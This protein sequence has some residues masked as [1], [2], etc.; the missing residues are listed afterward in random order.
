MVS[1]END[2]ALWFID[3]SQHDNPHT[4]VARAHTVP[5]TGALQHGLRELAHWVEHGIKPSE[6]TYCVVDGQVEVPET[7]ELRMGVQPV[8]HLTVERSKP[9]AGVPVTLT[10]TVDAPPGGGMI[11][12]AE[13]DFDGS[14]DFA[15]AATAFDPA[16]H[17]ELA[18][19]HI[20]AEPGTYFAALR[21]TSQREDAPGTPHCRLQNLAR[22][23]V[24]I[25]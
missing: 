22:V 18:A 24:V 14:G 1:F 11:I 25:R 6:T 12:A 19:A 15:V 10:G 9:T 23:R 3:H 4:A 17:V 5:L 8:V 7:A 21:V 16:Y 13:W 20:Y 2:F